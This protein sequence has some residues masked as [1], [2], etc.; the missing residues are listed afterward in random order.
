MWYKAAYMEISVLQSGDCYYFMF[1]G[2]TFMKITNLNDR[3]NQNLLSLEAFH[4]G[5]H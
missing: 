5:E 2:S 4:S 1:S 3:F